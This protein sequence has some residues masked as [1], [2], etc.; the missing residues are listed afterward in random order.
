[1][2]NVPKVLQK[3]AAFNPVRTDVGNGGGVYL[4]LTSCLWF[5]DEAHYVSGIPCKRVFTKLLIVNEQRYTSFA[6]IS[7]C[8][9]SENSATFFPTKMINCWRKVMELKEKK[10]LHNNLVWL[11]DQYPDYVK[12][13]TRL[14]EKF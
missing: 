8:L 11:A 7:K 9:F 5:T 4:Y 2:S 1:M 13:K 6:G 10:I 14:E 3:L 12:I